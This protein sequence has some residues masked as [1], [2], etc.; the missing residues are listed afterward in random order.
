LGYP[1]FQPGERNIDILGDFDHFV[2]QKVPKYP[3]IAQNSRLWSF[4][5]VLSYFKQFFV[6][7]S[8]FA[9]LG[10]FSTEAE[11]FERVGWSTFLA[12]RV[13]APTLFRPTTHYG[14]KA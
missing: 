2:S 7:L 8:F 4:E 3:K 14:R 11:I 13:G 12:E 9:D 6:I 1:F 5:S 10:W